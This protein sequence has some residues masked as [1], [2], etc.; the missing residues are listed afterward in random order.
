VSSKVICPP[1]WG[2]Y[3]MTKK[4]GLF[5]NKNLRK[6]HLG[7][8]VCPSVEPLWLDIPVAGFL[9][10]SL[11]VLPNIRRPHNSLS[12]TSEKSCPRSYIKSL[13]CIRIPSYDFRL[14]ST[15]NRLYWP[16][17]IWSVG[18]WWRHP[19]HNVPLFREH[20]KYVV[21][22]RFVDNCAIYRFKSS[23]FLK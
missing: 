13:L 14:L 23:M 10:S 2:L 17:V 11:Y 21:F 18:H 12:R 7:H 6:R 19:Y 1:N 3:C 20:N 9:K 16:S 4:T 5:S 22:S 8:A 15:I